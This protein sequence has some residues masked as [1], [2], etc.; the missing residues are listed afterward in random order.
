MR[1]YN[2]PPDCS[3]LSRRRA[4]IQAP[5]RSC[6]PGRDRSPAR[7]LLQYIPSEKH[8]KTYKAQ[9]HRGGRR[10]FHHQDAKAPRGTKIRSVVAVSTRYAYRVPGFV[11][12]ASWVRAKGHVK[13][14][15]TERCGCVHLT[16]D[17]PRWQPREGAMMV[18]G[19]SVGIACSLVAIA[20]LRTTDGGRQTT[21]THAPSSLVCGLSSSAHLLR[22]PRIRTRDAVS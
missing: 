10:G 16:D 8:S 4:G 9:R 6:T 14:L 2:G 19:T 18:T 22:Y 11:S 15:D 12:G 13:G 21:R 20:T 5:R 7:R 3:G 1:A 17:N